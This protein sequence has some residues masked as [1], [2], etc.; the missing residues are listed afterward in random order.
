[1]L[2]DRLFPLCR[3]HGLSSPPFAGGAGGRRVGV[4][5]EK[6]AGLW[7]TVG[8]AGGWSPAIGPAA[9][10][11]CHII[12]SRLNAP[13]SRALA[14][15]AQVVDQLVGRELCVTSVPHLYHLRYDSPLWN[16]LR[17]RVAGPL[18]VVN[19]LHPRPTEWILR[20]QGIAAEPLTVLDFRVFNSPEACVS[21]VLGALGESGKDKGGL[22]T[23]NEAVK[24]RW[25]PVIDGSRC[26]NCHHCMQFC[27]FGVYGLDS[28]GQLVVNNPDKC[29]PGC[30]A[31]AR[32]CPEGAI[33]FPLY[34]KDEAIA[35]VPG[36][37][38]TPDLAARR[39]FYTRT[40]KPCTRCGT[41]LKGQKQTAAIA[42]AC[43]ECGSALSTSPDQS[44]GFED[45]DAL[46]DQLEQLT[47]RKS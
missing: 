35:G 34:D 7:E 33:M 14:F 32:I 11:K 44:A 23:L 17:G 27:L 4:V 2:R 47:R 21:A 8:T 38:M 31:C 25:Y 41:V 26:V 12:I 30:P 40:G 28:A 18:V 1:M 3:T 15:E 22:S 6:S 39:M 46:V 10:S 9:M 42:A 24:T 45:L 37:F 16:E 29:K 43:P 36:R 19:R 13:D 5:L 20:Q